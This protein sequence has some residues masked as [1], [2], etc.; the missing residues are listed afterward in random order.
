LVVSLLLS[1]LLVLLG[2][3]LAVLRRMW[4][5]AETRLLLLLLLLLRGTVGDH[6]RTGCSTTVHAG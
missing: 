2:L 1:L 5:A 6:N 3:S 4:P